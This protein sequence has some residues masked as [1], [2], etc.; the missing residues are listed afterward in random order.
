MVPRSHQPRGAEG[1]LRRALRP[2]RR[3]RRL[4][5]DLPD[6]RGEPSARARDVRR[7]QARARRRSR[8][9]STRFTTRTPRS[10]TASPTRLASPGRSCACPSISR[11][12][13]RRSRPRPASASSRRKSA[14]SNAALVRQTLRGAPASAPRRRAGRRDPRRAAEPRSRPPSTILERERCAPDRRD[15]SRAR[16][17]KARAFI[18]E[19]TAGRARRGQDRPRLHPR[20]RVQARRGGH[21]ARQPEDSRRLRVQLHPRP[22]GRHRSAARRRPGAGV[23]RPGRRAVPVA[24]TS[25]RCAASMATPSRA[26]PTSATSRSASARRWACS[27]G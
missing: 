18:G 16:S 26:P 21:A 12:S 24:P 17:S 15:R 1:Q 13:S 3:E 11:S 6:R 25:P 9:F 7:I 5:A 8:R 14:C 2:D 4:A 22:P 23:R 20:L 10:A 27:P 19:A